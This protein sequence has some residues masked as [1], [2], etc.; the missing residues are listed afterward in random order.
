MKHLM[1]A[2]AALSLL[3]TAIPARAESISR[4]IGK[5]TGRNVANSVANRIGRTI[6]K[7]IGRAQVIE[8]ALVITENE[9]RPTLFPVPGST[10]NL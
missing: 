1:L 5:Q 4:T 6:G 10:T 7:Q 2:L 9:V 8:S 3:A